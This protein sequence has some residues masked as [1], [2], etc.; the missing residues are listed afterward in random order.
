MNDED[1]KKID[2][3]ID[4]IAKDDEVSEA[5]ANALGEPV[6]RFQKWLDDLPKLD[7]A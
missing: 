1:R 3:I 7:M 2:A 6:E 5:F 4:L